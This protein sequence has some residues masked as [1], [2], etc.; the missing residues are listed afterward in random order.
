MLGQWPLDQ[1]FFYDKQ[2]HLT[3]L[4]RQ[5]IYINKEQHE[6]ADI[7]NHTDLFNYLSETIE[8]N[9]KIALFIDEVQ[10]IKSFE[11]VL[12][13]LVTRENYDIYCTGSNANLLSGELATFLSGR[14]IE[15]RV[16][17]L[18]YEEFLVFYDLKD[19]TDNFLHYLKIG[20]LPFLI[21]LNSGSFFIRCFYLK[22]CIR[23]IK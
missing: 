4:K 11:I 20:G 21:N 6:F 16:H 17:G 23:L 8:E 14:Y 22:M 5:I 18:S 3:V 7:K 1:S 2:I 15:I 13:D 19:T 10:D 9:K 12:R